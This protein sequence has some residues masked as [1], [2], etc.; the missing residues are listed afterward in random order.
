MLPEDGD[1]EDCVM[2]YNYAS[3]IQC[4]I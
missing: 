4:C 2:L 1:F 3:F